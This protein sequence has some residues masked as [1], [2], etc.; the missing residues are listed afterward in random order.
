MHSV[1]LKMTSNQRNTISD[2][3]FNNCYLHLVGTGRWLIT[4]NFFNSNVNEQGEYAILWEATQAQDPM[5]QAMIVN[6]HVDLRGTEANF[7]FIRLSEPSTFTW[8]DIVS[9]IVGDNIVNGNS[10]STD[11]INPRSTYGTL[12]I[13]V[14]NPTDW[15]GTVTVVD[16]TTH[17]LNPEPDTATP[18]FNIDGYSTRSNP[19]AD[20]FMHDY[21][22][23]HADGKLS[24]EFNTAFAGVLTVSYRYGAQF[25]RLSAQAS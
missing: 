15:T 24:M 1:G 7:D 3:Y 8:G 17:I 9:T 25:K 13:D 10:T 20:V 19:N 4:D 12:V 21:S 16:L 5:T 6:N 11:L 14:E 22:Y 2:S 23:D 18:E